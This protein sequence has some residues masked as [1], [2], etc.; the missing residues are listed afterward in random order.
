[1]I[2]QP[3]TPAPDRWRHDVGEV[4]VPD[5]GL[6][7]VSQQAAIQL[8]GPHAQIPFL[9]PPG[10]VLSQR[11][12]AGEGIEP[13][14]PGDVGFGLG[15]EFLGVASARKGGRRC[16][17]LTIGSRV[18]GLPASGGELPNATKA[19]PRF[20]VLPSGHDALRHV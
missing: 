10:R 15:Q 18:S 12:P 14:A 4:E 13:V 6:D 16:P 5:P 1:M 2:A 11:H 19:A 3:A 17:E 8:G 7:V 20:P 9:D